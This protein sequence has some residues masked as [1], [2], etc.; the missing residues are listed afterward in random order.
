MTVYHI[1]RHSGAEEWVSKK[2]IEA[3]IMASLD[4]SRLRAGDVVIGTLPAHLAAEVCA[5]GAEYWHLCMD[6]P[7]EARGRDLSA[8]EMDKFNAKLVR[9][10]IERVEG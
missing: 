2:G 1:T 3:E 7:I 8:E 9:Y 10:H 5:S 6:L 4:L